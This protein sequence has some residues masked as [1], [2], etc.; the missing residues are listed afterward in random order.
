MNRLFIQYKRLCHSL[1]IMKYYSVYGSGQRN[2]KDSPQLFQCPAAW[3]I[4]A[5][6]FMLPRSLDAQK[7]N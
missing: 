4:F 3:T 6:N 5:L 7:Y 2:R 1:Q